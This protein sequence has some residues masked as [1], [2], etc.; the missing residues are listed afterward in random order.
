M[1]RQ[2]THTMLCYVVICTITNVVNLFV[3]LESF[4]RAAIKD[5]HLYQLLTLSSHCEGNEN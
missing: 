3:T 1:V 4:H 2:L 5:I